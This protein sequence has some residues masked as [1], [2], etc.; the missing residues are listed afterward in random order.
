MKKEEK[1]KQ[2]KQQPPHAPLKPKNPDTKGSP[3]NSDPEAQ[4]ED[5]DES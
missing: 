3:D 4:Y 5:K 1:P 2:S